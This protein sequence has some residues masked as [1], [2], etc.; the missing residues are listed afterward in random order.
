M[1][2]WRDHLKRW[3]PPALLRWR[4]RRNSNLIRFTGNY[5][6]YQ[7]AR[8]ASTG[9]D[10][11]LIQSR[12]IAAQ[13]KVRAGEGLFA[14]DGVVIQ[15]APPPI[16]LL[17]ILYQVALEKE[18]KVV[19][20]IDF[21]GA[22]GSTYDRCR[23]MAPSTL[24]FNWTIIE[25][26]ALVEAGQKE[27]STDELC[28]SNSL[29]ESLQS[30]P[31]DLLLLSGVLP[32][33]EEPFTLLSQIAECKIPWIIIDRTPLL[34]TGESRLTVQHVPASIY[35][36]PQSYPAWF[37]DHDQLCSILTPH[38]KLLSLHPSEDGE[39]DLGDVMSMSYGMIW[40]RKP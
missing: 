21:G 15:S 10:A 13:K 2:R 22:L 34:F 19:N 36:S 6:D 8:D 33:L 27:F 25:Q 23:A 1:S 31:V 37:L 20:V 38:Y 14:Q 30:Q 5:T 17:A 4:R 7:S 24:H 32:Y 18:T 9:Y 39:F 28:F 40:K 12:V 26:P 3:L 35:G 29:E 11:D 16:R